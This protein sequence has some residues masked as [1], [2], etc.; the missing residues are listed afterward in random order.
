MRS[1]LGGAEVIVSLVQGSSIEMAT[2]LCSGIICGYTMIGGLGAT[3]YASYFN[4]AFIFIGMF[5]YCY[6]V[7]FSGGHGPLGKAWE[8]EGKRG[9]PEA[10]SSALVSAAAGC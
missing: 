4:T 9:R 7:Y 1:F 6:N 2:L 5:I 8:L 3:F 10:S